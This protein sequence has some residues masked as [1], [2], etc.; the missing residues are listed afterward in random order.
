METKIYSFEETLSIGDNEARFEQ[1]KDQARIPQITSSI[2]SFGS[3]YCSLGCYKF[4]PDACS[5]RRADIKFVKKDPRFETPLLPKS[6]E[7][8]RKCMWRKD[9]FVKLSEEIQNARK[10]YLIFIKTD[11]MCLCKNRRMRLHFVITQK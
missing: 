9:G 4:S 6:R 8:F 7:D 1:S 10:V 3:S 5:T 11:Y 2:I